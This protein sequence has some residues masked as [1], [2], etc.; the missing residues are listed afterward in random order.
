VGQSQGPEGVR[1]KLVIFKVDEAFDSEED[2]RKEKLTPFPFMLA[3]LVS[4]TVQEV[5]I[6]HE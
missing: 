2:V 5:E 4:S 3:A 1:A 6:C